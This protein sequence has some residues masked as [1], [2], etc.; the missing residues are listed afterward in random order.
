MAAVGSD[1]GSCGHSPSLEN[2]GSQV[3]VPI[4]LN[5]HQ[6]VVLN[7]SRSEYMF[8][9]WEQSFRKLRAHPEDSISP[10]QRQFPDAI[11]VR[12]QGAVMS[13]FP[14]MHESPIWGPRLWPQGVYATLR[15][16]A[17]SKKEI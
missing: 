17:L 3:Q 4:R 8:L 14:P 6:G 16:R 9:T 10:P 2:L 1:S 7:T 15:G 12:A 5:Q 13:V 11:R